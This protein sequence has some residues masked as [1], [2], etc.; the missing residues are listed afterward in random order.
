MPIT[1][2][3]LPYALDALGP[4]MS[5]E[6]LDY[7]HNKHHRTYVET[8]NRLIEDT[9]AA[10]LTLEE[11]IRSSEGQVFDNA[12]QVWNH[13]FFWNSMAPGGGGPP[14]GALGRRL[15]D[16][17]GSYHA[18]ASAFSTAATGR[19]GSGWVWLVL[20]S[21][22]KLAITTTANA[23][24][25]LKQDEKALL[26]LDIWEHAYY[27]DHRNARPKFV[28]AFLAKLV[29]WDFAAKNFA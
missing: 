19:F 25:P 21:N 20:L 4:H 29:N 17:F 23:D 13:D 24:L 5:A 18:F 11:I 16:A 1:L 10:N 12:A 7:H 26:T 28:E 14:K 9:F 22:G 15:D 2:S 8:L 3:P 6:T 27:I